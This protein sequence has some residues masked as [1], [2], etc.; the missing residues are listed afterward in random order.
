MKHP[1]TI[2]PTEPV[3]P[4]LSLVPTDSL[5]RLRDSMRDMANDL[6]KDADR[7]DAEAARLG[8]EYEKRMRMQP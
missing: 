8:G 2:T 6:R 7:W 4:D 1:N 5:P 3:T